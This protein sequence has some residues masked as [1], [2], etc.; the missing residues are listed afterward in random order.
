MFL[1]LLAGGAAHDAVQLLA[2]DVGMPGMPAGL[3]QDVDQDVEQPD[4]RPRPP[5]H[6]AGRV[7]VESVDRRVGVV[8]SAPEHP[9]DAGPRLVL[10]D[11]HV[12][13]G[14]GAVVPPGQVLGERAPEDRAEV[15]RL[16][17]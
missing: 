11:P 17:D 12:G 15:P 5:R 4:V 6:V 7:D 1:Q 2:Q 10:G 8:A 9:D 16:P 13:A 3:G 14:F